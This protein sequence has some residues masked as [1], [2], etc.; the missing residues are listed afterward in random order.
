MRFILVGPLCSFIFMLKSQT[1]NHAR[2]P[3]EIMWAIAHLPVIPTPI[4][5]LQD[6]SA[7]FRNQCHL[8]MGLLIRGLFPRK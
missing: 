5:N 8:R 2:K 4:K 6:I 1:H 7:F 3:P